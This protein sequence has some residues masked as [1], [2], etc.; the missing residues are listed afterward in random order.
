MYKLQAGYGFAF[1]DEDR[2]IMDAEGGLMW[3]P[4]LGVRFGAAKSA[5]FMF[6]FGVKVQTANYIFNATNVQQR[7]S[8]R[9]VRIKNDMTYRRFVVRTAILF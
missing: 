1:K 6:D 5:N 3:Y 7:W 4:A 2:N 9:E 8:I